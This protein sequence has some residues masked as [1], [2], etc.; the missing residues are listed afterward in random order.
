MA[1][2]PIAD[3]PNGV[4]FIDSGCSNHMSSSKSL[5]GDLDETKISQ[6]RF[7]DNNKF[8]WKETVQLQSKQSRVV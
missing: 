4:W 3:V 2:S 6:V 7:E 8:A 1:H 5:F